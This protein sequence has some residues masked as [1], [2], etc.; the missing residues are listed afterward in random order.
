MTEVIEDHVRPHVVDPA[1]NA[2]R[3]RGAEEVIEAV[4]AYLK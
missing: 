1:K 3:K 2:E 4:H